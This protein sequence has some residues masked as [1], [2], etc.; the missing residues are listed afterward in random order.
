MQCRQKVVGGYQFS[1]REPATEREG[2]GREGGPKPLYFMFFAIQS[3]AKTIQSAAKKKTCSPSFSRYTDDR[4]H[5]ASTLHDSEPGIHRGRQDGGEHVS[6]ALDEE[7]YAREMLQKKSTLEL[8][9][10]IMSSNMTRLLQLVEEMHTES[11]VRPLKPSQ[12]LLP[13]PGAVPG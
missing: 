2:G 3:A 7:R 4:I 11:K 12:A 8:R 9:M 6:R 1:W 5:E 10:D 13:L